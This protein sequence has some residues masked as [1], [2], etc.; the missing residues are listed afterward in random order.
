MKRIGANGG[1]S[2]KK[3]FIYLML[4]DC[5]S[6]IFLSMELGISAHSCIKNCTFGVKLHVKK[7]W[8]GNYLADLAGERF[9]RGHE[10]GGQREMLPVQ[11]YS[12]FCGS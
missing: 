3:R 12:E 1:L 5:I 11:K 6:D 10:K 2:P 9:L 4:N 7:P 8:L